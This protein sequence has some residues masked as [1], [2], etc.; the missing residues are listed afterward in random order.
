MK[1]KM[2]AFF[3]T[4]MMAGTLLPVF[5]AS[6]N[7]ISDVKAFKEKLLE[8]I[9]L[10]SVTTAG[11][12]T[13]A[14]VQLPDYSEIFS[15]IDDNLETDDTE[16]FEEELYRE[17]A[18]KIQDNPET[19]IREVTVSSEQTNLDREEIEALI[20][21][22][23][24]NLEKQEYSWG[25]LMGLFPDDLHETEPSTGHSEII[26]PGK[27]ATCTKSGLTEGR[28][29]SV[30][31]TII[32]KQEVIPTFGHNFVN[33]VCSLCGENN[34]AA[35]K[36]DINSDGDINSADVNLLYRVVMGY[37][38]LSESSAADTNNDGNINSA[39]VNLLYRYV[40]GYIQSLTLSD[41]EAE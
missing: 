34:T 20:R 31:G 1:K 28:K 17:T 25:L 32:L 6:Q 33:G 4:I 2:I 10:E 39:D 29:C 38:E 23:A 12:F 27:T 21:E 24:L 3:V 30:C 19:T 37:A 16:V 5:A 18:L 26:I 40:M 35:L 7:I 13:N 22:E 11:K 36:G 41:T 9:T 14:N 15:E 8:H